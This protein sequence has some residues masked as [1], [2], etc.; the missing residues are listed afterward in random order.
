[1]QRLPGTAQTATGV[2]EGS[3]RLLP[4][5]SFVGS[6]LL[7]S[8]SAPL[9]PLRPEAAV[10]LH[11]ADAGR[12]GLAAGVSARLTTR[13]GHLQATVRLEEGMAPGLAIVPRLRGSGL[14]C[15]VPGGPLLDCALEKGG[16]E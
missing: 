10:L 11:P 8:L 16:D 14:E 2:A 12:L 3:L 7:S 4:V 9:T 1:V 6:E 15:L 13:F 5:E